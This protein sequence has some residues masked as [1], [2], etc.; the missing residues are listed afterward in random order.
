MSNMSKAKEASLKSKKG[1]SFVNPKCILCHFYKTYMCFGCNIV[2][3]ET[4]QSNNETCYLC[5]FPYVD[6]ITW[7][8]HVTMLIDQLKSLRKQMCFHHTMYHETV[9]R[10][11]NCLQCVK[12]VNKDTID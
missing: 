2:K 12:H 11:S 4:K 5:C 7:D 9:G 6:E 10:K 8:S 1:H 3:N